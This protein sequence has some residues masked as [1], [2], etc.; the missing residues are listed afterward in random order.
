MKMKSILFAVLITLSTLL[1][2]VTNLVNAKTTNVNS[3]VSQ[4]TDEFRVE[5]VI[6]NSVIWKI[7]YDSGGNVVQASAVSHVD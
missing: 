7:V 3:T 2:G 6:I 1:F 5:Y 4:L